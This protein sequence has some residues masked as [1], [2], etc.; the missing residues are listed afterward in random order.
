M[1]RITLWEAMDIVLNERSNKTMHAKEIAEEVTKQKLYFQ[2]NGE[3]VK[4]NQI[5]ARAIHKPEFFECLK[6]NYIRLIKRYY[7]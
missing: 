4:Y 2:L 7:K 1:K 6:G 5:R 3:E